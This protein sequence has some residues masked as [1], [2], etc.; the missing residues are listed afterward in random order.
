MQ[1]KVAISTAKEPKRILA[2]QAWR[3]G[4]YPFRLRQ[5]ISGDAYFEEAYV[6]P[7][8]VPT[9]AASLQSPS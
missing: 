8:Q 1:V 3:G 9:A 6:Y 7:A 4:A 5:E 2:A